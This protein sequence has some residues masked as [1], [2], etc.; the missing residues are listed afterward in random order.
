MFLNN[1]EP[2][3][4]ISRADIEAVN[5]EADIASLLEIKKGTALIKLTGQLLNFD[6]KILDYSITY[7]IPGRIKFNIMRRVAT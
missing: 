1:G 7:F 5:A 4:V 2:V 3:P 6:D